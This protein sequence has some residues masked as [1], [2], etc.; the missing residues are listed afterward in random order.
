MN[1]HTCSWILG[2]T[3]AAVFVMAW[4]NQYWRRSALV[5][6]TPV[7]L[8]TLV[9]AGIYQPVGTPLR[10]ILIVG[11]FA[12]GVLSWRPQWADALFRKHVAALL[13]AIGGGL[14]LTGLY[15]LSIGDEP[16]AA[17]LELAGFAALL[18][19]PVFRAAMQAH[20]S[21]NAVDDSEGP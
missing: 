1:A 3:S 10:A 17:V 21:N 2:S 9:A 15:C 11:W 20:A 18:A 16:S 5:E 8:A 12:L 7:I 19:N 14:M 4:W 13:I 6:L